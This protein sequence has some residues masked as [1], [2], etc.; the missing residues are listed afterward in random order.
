MGDAQTL[1][2]VV[3]GRTGQH[4]GRAL[5]EHRRWCRVNAVPVPAAVDALLDLLAASGGQDGPVL[6]AVPPAAQTLAVDYEGAAVRLS[7]SPRTVR[8]LV[9]A[10][11]LLTVRVG[12]RRLISVEAL[13]A[14]ARGGPDE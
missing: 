3:D 8:R 11:D 5:A 14:F 6:R 2:M 1:V 9:A 12:R 10:G 4:L 7:V 13:E